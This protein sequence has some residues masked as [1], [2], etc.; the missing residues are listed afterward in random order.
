MCLEIG[1][2]RPINTSIDRGCASSSSATG[3]RL[4]YLCV[5]SRN[6]ARARECGI[7]QKAPEFFST[8]RTMSKKTANPEVDDLHGVY[9]SAVLAFNAASAALIL[10]LA[11][12]SLPTDGE[13]AAEEESRDAVVAARRRLWAA[14][15]QR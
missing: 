9:A 8:L 12:N 13:I 7:A 14:Y 6:C 15:R 10:H 5:C 2:G 11:A 4:L 1:S 3:W